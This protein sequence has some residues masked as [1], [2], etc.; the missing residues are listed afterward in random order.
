VVDIGSLVFE[1]GVYY[2]ADC[3]A[4]LNATLPGIQGWKCG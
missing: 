1:L 2:E 4:A 3:F